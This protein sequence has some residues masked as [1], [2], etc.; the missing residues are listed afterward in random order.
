M[1]RILWLLAVVFFAAGMIFDTV[2]LQNNIQF[3]E[4]GIS[5]GNAPVYAISTEPIFGDISQKFVAHRGYSNGAPEN[6]VPAFELAGRC[7]FWGIETDIIESADG[8]FMCMHDET[9]ERTTDGVGA[10][11]DYTYAQLMDFNIDKGSNIEQHQDLKIPTM[12][13][14]LNICVINGCV[15]VIEIKS[16]RNYD[17][18]L[19][20]I[21]NSGLQNRCIVTGGMPDLLE[22]RARNDSIPLMPI[23]YSNKDYTYY[24]EQVSQ[25]ADNRGILYNY[26]VVT[27]DVVRILHEQGIYCGVWSLDTA[28][29]AKKFLS[30]GVDFVV[31]N[32]IPGL[33]H[34]INENE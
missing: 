17:A 21:Y 24:L 30:Y 4:N 10:L 18:F 31:T 7:G 2:F 25:L 22:I 13:E 26:P 1:R 5:A 34:M 32:E 11:S 12:I 23:G 8:V 19:E 28:D 33:N 14:Y 6:S 9:L 3:S 15:P 16:I 20:T 29:E 27:E